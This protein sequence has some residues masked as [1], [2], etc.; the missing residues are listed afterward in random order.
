[1]PGSPIRAAAVARVLLIIGIARDED[2]GALHTHAFKEVSQ[3]S[4]PFNA[5]QN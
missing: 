4:S 5:R 2:A 3:T 1:M